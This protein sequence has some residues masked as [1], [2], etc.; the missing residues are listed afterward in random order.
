[1]NPESHILVV[2]DDADISGLIR[3]LLEGE[4]YEVTVAHNGL[5]ALNLLRSGVAPC[6]ILLDLEMPV[7]N[8]RQLKAELSA[9]ERFRD[10]PVAVM[11]A[12]RDNLKSFHGSLRKLR[13]P[14]SLRELIRAVGE[15]CSPV[16][17]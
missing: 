7:M 5:E 17:A 10:L 13:K 11:S 1:M 4:G 9:D 2:E 15:H 3:T 12:S 14:F 16:G 6:L 8:G